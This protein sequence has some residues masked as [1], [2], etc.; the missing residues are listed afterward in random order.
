MCLCLTHTAHLTDLLL[1]TLHKLRS[2]ACASDNKIKIIKKNFHTDRHTCTNLF[3]SLALLD[4][5][6]DHG[7]GKKDKQKVQKA[8][9]LIRGMGDSETRET[10]SKFDKTQVLSL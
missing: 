6:E 1:H 4:V 9:I 5:P 10:Y 7:R 3:P 8:E 2:A